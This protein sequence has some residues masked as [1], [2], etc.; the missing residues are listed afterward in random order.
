MDIIS[1]DWNGN[2]ELIDKQLSPNLGIQGNLDPFIL[3]GSKEK[4]FKLT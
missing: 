3:Y 2:L 1:L 4:Q